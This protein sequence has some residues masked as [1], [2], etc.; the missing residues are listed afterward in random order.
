M[1]NLLYTDDHEAWIYLSNLQYC[2]AKWSDESESRRALLFVECPVP[3]SK[4]SGQSDLPQ[5]KYEV[6]QP[7]QPKYVV[8]LKSQ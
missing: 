1:G 4:P 3:G 2:P 7:E 8:E 6:G 5:G